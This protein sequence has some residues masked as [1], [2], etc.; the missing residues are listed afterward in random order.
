MSGVYVRQARKMKGWTQTDLA[1]KL[2]VSQAYVS[3]LEAGRRVVADRLVRKLV[4]VLGL[5]PSTLP[6]SAKP[7]PL[8][9]DG[10]ARALG[11]LGYSGFA[12]LRQTR[13]LNPAE[14]L[15]RTLSSPNVEA[16][17]VEALPW[18]L[19]NYP[20]VDWQWLLATAKQNDL[21]NRLGFV[22]T[23][24]REVAESRGNPAAETLRN[25]ERVLENSLLQKEDAF[26]RDGLTEA[27]RKWLRSNRSPEAAH[28]NLLTNLSAETVTSAF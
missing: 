10:V 17:L 19:V 4:S 24:A 1:Q 7:A 27:E 2:G 25:W 6:I 18:L 26:S 20:K 3:L 22:V 15:V 14:L 21:Q 13:K 11:T 12:H 28:W 8:T 16:R 9:P 23:V 5:P